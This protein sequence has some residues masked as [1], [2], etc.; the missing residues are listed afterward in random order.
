LRILLLHS[1]YTLRGGEDIVFEQ[2]LNLLRE[3]NEV[4]TLTFTNNNGLKGAI[5]FL[6]SIW[7][8]NAAKKLKI[9]VALF[10][11]DVIHI[12]NW[13]FA[14]GPIIIRTA[15]KLKIPIVLTLHNYRLL[16]PSGTLLHKGDIYTESL[17]S[18]FPWKA[19]FK[20]VY[21][22]SALQTFWLA[23][24]VWFHKIIGTWQMVNVY[25]N[26]TSFAQNI[27]NS[28]LLLIPKEKFVVKPNFVVGTNAKSKIANNYFLFVGRLSEE[29][30]IRVLLQAFNNTSE[31]L[32]IAGQGPL[33]EEVSKH[34]KANK[35]I[36]YLGSLDGNGVKLAMEE[37]IALIC[38][39]ICFEGM[40]LTILE[41]FSI[42]T[43][44][45]ASNLGGMSSMI[46]HGYN[47]LHFEPGNSD[48]LLRKIIYFKSLNM[49]NRVSFGC[50]AEKTYQSH[51]TPSINCALLI[52]IYKSII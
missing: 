4:E 24:V 46:I 43:P 39:S 38:P 36:Q 29:K 28:S 23:L 17:N 1:Y 26:L 14:L 15:K 45:I 8:I 44:V 16:C 31:I 12:H 40:P 5:Q 35:N 10:K 42:G 52:S 47:G 7:N 48:A 3:H 21:R 22:N 6:L 34:V 2:E 9:K 27:Y 25:I 30:G 20:K 33:H 11:P 19:I 32:K 49:E 41:A 51:Y 50:N 13:H 18:T 37:C